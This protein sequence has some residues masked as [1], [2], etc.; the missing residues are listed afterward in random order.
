MTTLDNVTHDL[1][2]LRSEMNAVK[3]ELYAHQIMFGDML[4]QLI[5]LRPDWRERLAVLR[6]NALNGARNFEL[7]GGGPAA[8]AALQREIASRIDEH[9]S[10]VLDGLSA[11]HGRQGS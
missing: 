2:N 10:T 6:D 3:A 8:N 11:W 5:Y 9:F 1:L 7:I 4:T